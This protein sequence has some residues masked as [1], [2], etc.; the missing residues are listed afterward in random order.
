MPAPALGR[1]G[2]IQLGLLVVGLAYVRPVKLP[3]YIVPADASDRDA[4]EAQTDP[5]DGIFANGFE[6]P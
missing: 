2:L 6:S 5:Y 3:A 4:Y 1:F